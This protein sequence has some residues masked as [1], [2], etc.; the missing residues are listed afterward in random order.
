MVVFSFDIFFF[1][2][3]Y[4]YCRNVEAMKSFHQELIHN[5]V[6]CDRDSRQ[7]AQIYCKECKMYL[8]VVTD[9]L[10]H[11][12]TDHF[13]QFNYNLSKKKPSMPTRQCVF[14]FTRED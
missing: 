10:L 5:G 7:I 6:A 12:H 9:S 11:I 13:S 1:I 3:Y 8:G 4:S 2:A 14:P